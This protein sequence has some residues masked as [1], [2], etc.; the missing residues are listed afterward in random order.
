MAPEI[1]IPMIINTPAEDVIRS[2]R[3]SSKKFPPG[4]KKLNNPANPVIIIR[5]TIQ[6]GILSLIF[7]MIPILFH[8]CHLWSGLIGR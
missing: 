8:A 3:N 4:I 5:I 2:S 6:N 7:F 1:K